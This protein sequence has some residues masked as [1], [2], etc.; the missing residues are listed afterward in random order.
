[1]RSRPQQSYSPSSSA[2]AAADPWRRRSRQHYYHHFC[3]RRRTSIMQMLQSRQSA[4]GA[5]D[6]FSVA[7]ARVLG[8]FLVD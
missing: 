1:M 4:P 5:N 6:S 3:G 7:L 2:A 8:V